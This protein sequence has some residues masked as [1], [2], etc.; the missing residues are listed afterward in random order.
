MVVNKTLTTKGRLT[1]LSTPKVMGILNI[2]PDSFYDGGKYNSPAALL[3]RAEMI[4]KDG[5]TFLDIGGYSSRPGAQDISEEEEN[6][7]VLPAV[8]AVSQNFP[9]AIISID[10]FRSTVARRA[11]EAGAAM[12]NDISGGARD[13][14]MM[15][16][17]ATLGVSLII[18]H[19]KGTPQNMNS[20]ATYENLL[21]EI[22]DHLSEKINAAHAL[23]IRD[24]IIDPGFGFAKTVEQN[25]EILKHLDY[26]KIL[27]KPILAGLS[28]KSLIWRTLEI[29]PEDALNGTT[30]LNTIALLK[31]ASILR[32]HDV[33]EAAEVVKLINFVR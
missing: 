13:E 9:E 11:V 17:V 31:G 2:T 8:E 28:R 29:T 14:K 16:V 18:M 21:K 24:I 10:T 27:G 30:A 6:L 22:V 5:A 26:L 4:L 1:D 25:F 19:M 3:K 33:K 23:G 32:A 7:R 12:V 20:L 15:A